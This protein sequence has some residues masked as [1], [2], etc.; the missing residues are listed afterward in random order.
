[1]INKISIGRK[2]GELFVEVLL[3]VV[4]SILFSGFN[5]SIACFEELSSAVNRT[6]P[7]TCRTRAVC[8]RFRVQRAS[9]RSP[10][11]AVHEIV[12]CGRGK[13]DGM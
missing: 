13:I 1:M 9:G 3:I 7:R 5:V 12:A 11:L 8:E 2:T 4:P 6:T 10:V